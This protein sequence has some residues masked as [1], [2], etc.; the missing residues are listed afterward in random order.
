MLKLVATAAIILIFSFETMAY[1]AHNRLRNPVI[2]GEIDAERAKAVLSQLGQRSIIWHFP[3]QFSKK[4]NNSFYKN[5]SEKKIKVIAEGYNDQGERISVAGLVIYSPLPEKSGGSFAVY[6]QENSLLISV[7]RIRY[8]LAS[9]I[10][11]LQLGSSELCEMLKEET[12]EEKLLSLILEMRIS[13]KASEGADERIV[14]LLK[15]ERYSDRLKEQAIYALKD[16]GKDNNMPDD[17]LLELFEKAVSDDLRFAVVSLSK[18]ILISTSTHKQRFEK[19]LEAY[20]LNS[21]KKEETIDNK[22]IKTLWMTGEQAILSK[23]MPTLFAILNDSARLSRF[24]NVLSILRELCRY[25][26][27]TNIPAGP[28]C[29]GQASGFEFNIRE[30]KIVPTSESFRRPIIYTEWLEHDSVRTN[31]IYGNDGISREE[32]ILLIRWQELGM[33][34]SI[35]YKDDKGEVLYHTGT[36]KG[37]DYKGNIEISFSNLDSEIEWDRIISISAHKRLAIELKIPGQSFDRDA[38]WPEHFLLSRKLYKYMHGSGV[39]KPVFYKSIK[40]NFYMHGRQ[41]RFDKYSLG[42]ACFRYEEGKRLRNVTNGGSIFDML[43][44]DR[45]SKD[46]PELER[47]FL[48][49][50]MLNIYDINELVQQIAADVFTASICMH[51]LGWCA[52]SKTRNDMHPENI[53][54]QVVDGRAVLVADFGAAR[55]LGK[56]LTMRLRRQETSG[57]IG[58]AVTKLNNEVLLKILLKIFERLSIY[59]PTPYKRAKLIKE[60]IYELGVEERLKSLC[61]LLDTTIKRKEK[62]PEAQNE[63]DSKVLSMV[64]N[65]IRPEPLFDKTFFNATTITRTS[66]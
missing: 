8:I 30:L 51:H 29:I 35:A 61:D 56:H 17:L 47:Y 25:G 43:S 63:F 62:D 42:I 14:E 65:P 15:D 50:A 2:F 3:E 22:K 40:G 41:L 11:D 66:F 27:F 38:I 23:H 57:L 59:E 36:L 53:R 46:M 39:V 6:S 54:L 4:E 7:S 1:S 60:A 31:T 34:V 16:I 9:G 48:R 52:S 24:L 44:K 37:I 10:S 19:A 21:P 12:D 55:Y 49:L 18:M 5:L 26:I 33:N 20:I 32:L 58:G 64:L 45:L 13:G 28:I